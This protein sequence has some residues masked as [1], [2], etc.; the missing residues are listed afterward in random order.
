VRKEVVILQKNLTVNL[1]GILSQLILGGIMNRLMYLFFLVVF[2]GFS[3]ASAQLPFQIVIDDFETSAEDS[4]YDT[5]VEGDPSRIDLADNAEDFVEGSASMDAHYVIGEFNQWGSY[6]N[7]IY[8]EEGDA[9]Q[10]WAT[11]DSI[12]IWIKV[13]NAPNNPDWMVFRIHIA[14]RPTPDDQIEEYIYENTVVFNEATDWF[15]L[16]VP[17]LERDTDGTTVPND[18]GFVIFPDTWG[19]GTYNNRSLDRD[20]IVGYNL[21]AVVSGWDPANPLP[22]DSVKVSYDNFVRFGARAVPFIIFNGKSINSDLGGGWAWG[23]SSFYV[24]EG[25]GEDPK[26]NAIKWTQG[27]EWSNGWT[28]IGWDIDPSWNMFGAWLVDSVKFKMKAPEGTGALRMQFESASDGGKVGHVFTP[29]GDDQWH[30]YS[31]ALMDFVQTDGTTSFDTA[32]VTVIGLMAEG[33]GV[34]GRVIYIDNWWTDNPPIDVSPPPAPTALQVSTDTNANLITWLDSEGE[35]GETYNVYYSASPIDSVTGPGIEV[36]EQGM[37]VEEGTQN[38]T[39]LLFAPNEDAAVTFY[40]AVTAIDAAGNESDPVVT[41][42]ATSNTGKGIATIP[43]E[44]PENFKADGDL[45]EWAAMTPT[46][47]FVSEGAHVVTNTVVD[48]DDDCSGLIYLAAGDDSLYFA[49]DITDDIVNTEA[50]NSWEQDSPDL[51]IGLYHLTGKPHAGYEGDDE[52]DYH[53]RFNRAEILLDNA[54][55]AIDTAGSRYYW[56]EQFPSG[57]VVEGAMS[58]AEIAD[59]GD[60]SVYT[61]T[62]G[63]RL[64]FNISFSDADGGANVREG[65]LTLSRYDDDTAWQ[66]PRDWMYTWIW[67]EGATA[68][69]D[70]TQVTPFQYELS[71]NYPNPFNPTTTINYTLAKS[72]QVTLEVFNMLGQKV[73]TLVNTKQDAGSYTVQFNANDL[74]SGIYLY[75]LQSEGFMQVHKMVLLK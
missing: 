27:D 51:F 2:L 44:T 14:D 20:K 57:Y 37:G 71:K 26:T 53:F 7:L 25:A 29:I 73:K 75:R 66:T 1:L 36:V 72:G 8:R 48:N 15:E 45:S 34:A 18:E 30:D 32:G 69:G 55:V 62:H 43:M 38:L 54:G 52:P 65:I 49:F 3:T 74:A 70:L 56:E 47:L 17:L 64:P 39:H 35:T 5:D 59:A 9:T 22:A 19:G 10:D 4:I 46:R 63:D 60:D 42:S 61:P 12:S 21:S 24:E 68:I 31:F 16:K 11:S 28:G 23:Q 67:D 6:G 33:T 58:Y 13:H 50:G 40:Y 41:E